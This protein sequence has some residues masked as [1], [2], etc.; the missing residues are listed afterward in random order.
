MHVNVVQHMLALCLAVPQQGGL[1]LQAG[2]K[3]GVPVA[4]PGPI[5]PQ[6]VARRRLGWCATGLG[7]SN[8]CTWLVGSRAPCMCARSGW[9]AIGQIVG[10]KGSVWQQ[11]RH[12]G[13]HAPHLA[14]GGHLQALHTC[15]VTPAAARPGASATAGC[16]CTTQRRMTQRLCKCCMVPSAVVTAVH[17]W[18][19]RIH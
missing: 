14:Q 6:R 8:T 17:G 16:R 15:R 2:S 5:G 9:H 7:A 19:I 11:I 12:R 4:R 3:P 13:V 1:L 18:N 10:A